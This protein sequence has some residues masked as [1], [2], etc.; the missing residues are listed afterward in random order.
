MGERGLQRERGERSGN[1][2]R[3]AGARAEGRPYELKT[4]DI[5]MPRRSFTENL[6]DWESMVTNFEPLMTILPHIAEDHARLSVIATE[7]RALESEQDTHVRMIR[8]TNLKR[9]LLQVN[10]KKLHAK[11]EATARGHFGP[12]SIL[13]LGVGLKPRLPPRRRRQSPSE[14]KAKKAGTQAK[15]APPDPTPQEP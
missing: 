5:L 2:D 4:G 11:L 14:L 8:E 3:P 6:V 15:P 13:L 7:G 12:D 1:G 10:G 9:N